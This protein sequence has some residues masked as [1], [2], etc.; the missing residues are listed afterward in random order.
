VIISQTLRRAVQQHSNGTATI[1]KDRKQSWREFE[2][3]V[4]RLA[5]G[6]LS[7]GIER[8][9]RIAILSLNSDR[10]LEYFYA[11]PWAGAALNPVNIRL[12][13]PEIAFTLN[14]S[15]SSILFVDD[16]FSAMLP[17]VASAA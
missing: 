4:A 11:V 12:A 5:A 10:Y 3:R 6:L 14:D 7:L 9:S 15:G 16:T 13:P 17:E 8:G 2:D 1:Y